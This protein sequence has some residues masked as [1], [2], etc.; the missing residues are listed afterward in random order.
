MVSYHVADQSKSLKWYLTKFQESRLLTHRGGGTVGAQDS[1]LAILEHF[2]YAESGD[3][4]G[5]VGDSQDGSYH[6][7]NVTKVFPIYIANCP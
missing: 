4:P 5:E 2:Y 7:S 6:E 3:L 1:F